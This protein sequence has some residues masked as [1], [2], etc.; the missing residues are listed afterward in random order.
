MPAVQS[1]D[2]GQERVRGQDGVGVVV[3]R[4]G[5]VIEGHGL[6]SLRAGLDPAAR[7]A[8]GQV[9]ETGE[10]QQRFHVV[11]ADKASLDAIDDGGQVGVAGFFVVLVHLAHVVSFAFRLK[12]AGHPSARCKRHAQGRQSYRLMKE[13]R[14]IPAR[15]LRVRRYL[16]NEQR[17]RAARRVGEGERCVHGKKLYQM[18]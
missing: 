14:A 18:A 17:A 11:L 7:A 13:I 9:F 12:R 10:V 8:L 2:V 4:S 15:R 6:G 16:S 5:G 1:F 3:Q